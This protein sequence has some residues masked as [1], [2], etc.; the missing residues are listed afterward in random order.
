MKRHALRGNLVLPDR[1]IALGIVVIEGE[2]IAGIFPS[3]E[4]PRTPVERLVD[5]GEN[6]ITPGL[7]DLHLH[8]ALGR[9]V[10][11]GSVEGL[12]AIAAHQAS[13]GVTGFVPTT[14]SASIPSIL[15]AVRSVK[16][17]ARLA[18]PS[19]ILG[20]HLEGPFLNLKKRGAQNPDFIK[21]INPEDLRALA[22]ASRDLRTIITVAPEVGDNLGRIPEV[23]EKGLT[24]SIGHTEASYELALRSFEFG[25]THATHLYNAMSGFLPREPG[26]IG[27]VLDADSVTAEIIADGIH[28]HPASLRIAVRQKG[29]ARVCLITD[30][31]NATGLSDGA[32]RVGNL[33]VIL[34][35][36]EARLIEGG[37]LAG[38]VLT[39]NRAV[40]NIIQWTG[41]SPSDAVGMSSLTPARVLGLDK[42][43]GSIEKGKR[44]NLA[45][46]DRDFN[47]IDTI[48]RGQSVLKGQPGN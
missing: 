40:K 25:V 7:I 45:V 24:V 6:Y 42:E 22:E 35:Q 2:K 14:L 9:D 32:Y 41:V 27:A 1:Q 44:A 30:S 3:G 20:L 29:A 13:C 39:L 15:A 18:L 46:F 8:G 31:M 33:D 19:E 48:L 37:A 23:R 4:S 34:K 36:G 17:A 47:V 28:V 10:I 11:D 38:S 26:V 43:L 5:Y 16:S 21:P 12:Q